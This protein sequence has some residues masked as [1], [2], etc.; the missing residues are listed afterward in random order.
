MTE[1]PGSLARLRDLAIP[2]PVPFW[3]PAPGVWIVAAGCLA[4]LA[5]FAWRALRRYRADAYRRAALKELDG[6]AGTMSQADQAVVAQVSAILKRTALV[7]YPRP[8]VAALSGRA[9]AA[10]LAR[11]GMKGSTASRAET[12]LSEACG[13]QHDVPAV[14]LTAL[15]AQA[16]L[17]VRTHQAPQRLGET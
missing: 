3:P 16:R 12:L 13:R 7:A 17:W 5:V 2:P 11:N 6:V 9:W 14:E 4:M 10:F 8:D 1:D 15:I